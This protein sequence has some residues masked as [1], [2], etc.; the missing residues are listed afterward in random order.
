[1]TSLGQDLIW[2]M[3]L[4]RVGEFRG[5]HTRWKCHVRIGVLQ[6]MVPPVWVRGIISSRSAWFYKWTLTKKIPKT[7][8]YAVTNAG[9]PQIAE[10]HHKL[11]QECRTYSPCQLQASLLPSPSFQGLPNCETA[12]ACGLSPPR[13]YEDREDLVVGRKGWEDQD[14]DTLNDVASCIWHYVMDTALHIQ[15]YRTYNATWP[16]GRAVDLSGS[17]TSIAASTLVEEV[18]GVL[19][20]TQNVYFPFRLEN[21]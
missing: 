4:R 21:F 6:G 3:L 13:S 15:S 19:G 11:G 8:C 17:A 10:G 12:K 2:L 20:N 5:T 18:D 7:Q 1:M 9:T 16:W 14:R